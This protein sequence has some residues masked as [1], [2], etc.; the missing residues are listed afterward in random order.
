MTTTRRSSANNKSSAP[1]L[2]EADKN[3]NDG[4]I[5]ATRKSLRS[6]KEEVVVQL[7]IITRAH[8][9]ITVKQLNPPR[10]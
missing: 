9:T 2:G 5:S 7:E 1:P 6:H 8:P 3:T 4:G 10:L